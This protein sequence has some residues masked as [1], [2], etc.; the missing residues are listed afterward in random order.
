MCRL[1]EHVQNL[2]QPTENAPS[3]FI[4]T[5]PQRLRALETLPAIVRAH[6]DEPS[7]TGSALFEALGA[8]GAP[9]ADSGEPSWAVLGRMLRE[10]RFV[11][12]YRRLEL[13]RGPLGV[14]AGQVLK[15]ERGAVADH[16]YFLYL[17]S[18]A[19]PKD[20]AARVLD[21]LIGTLDLTNVQ[22]RS[23]PMLRAIEQSGH[24]AARAP[25]ALAL[26]HVNNTAPDLA[27]LV[28]S[29]VG[30]EQSDSAL[31]LL[32]VSPHS[33]YARAV[34]IEKDWER[35][36]P[37]LAE[38]QQAA[39][40][41]PVLLAALARKYSE[42]GQV[43]DARRLVLRYI[44]FSPDQWAYELLAAGYKDAGDLERWQATLD[45]YLAKTKDNER[46]RAFVRVRIA[47]SFM[48]QADWDKAW[49]YAQA[50]AGT[51]IYRALVCA[52]QC[53]EGRKDWVAAE[54]YTRQ[55]T[56][57]NPGGGW[58]GWYLFCKRTGHGNAEAAG[59]FADRVLATPGAGA[60]VAPPGA[61]GYFYWLRGDPKKAGT[62][63]R[64]AY[65]AS[66]S[67]M[68]CIPLIL[69]ADELG[70]AAARDEWIRTLTTR[71]RGQS[72]NTRPD[73]RGPR[74]GDR[75]GPAGCDRPASRRPDPRDDPRRRV[76]GEQ[77]VLRGLLPEEPRQGRGGPPTPGAGPPVD[78]VPPLHAGHRGGSAPAT[79]RR[80]Q[81]HRRGSRHGESAGQAV[82]PA[83]AGERK[84]GRRAGTG[85]G[86]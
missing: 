45:E 43:E 7:V 15:H 26:K 71:H 6:L 30:R 66:P 16:P 86:T 32:E 19:T 25:L 51:G 74:Q 47:E 3:I 49:P 35:A 42:R 68:T 69:V 48:G 10:T 81:G 84:R 63:F 61:I 28:R 38:W 40:R 37:H 5:V 57:S 85:S 76:P 23:E 11:Q 53:A 72:P 8:R 80:Y 12:V 41:S 20:R 31:A 83:P 58:A 67:A 9:G 4:Q 79:G 52:A 78:F 82:T 29:S 55:I 44:R 34:L 50:A 18:L 39:D 77:R 65:D 60:G 64:K 36:R 21:G 54:D 13:R 59:A 22:L 17:E 1:G 56:E 33:D 27:E 62:Y 46:S 14:V 70:D 2:D 75:A 73:L 24:A